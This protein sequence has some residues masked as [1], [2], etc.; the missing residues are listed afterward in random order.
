MSKGGH[1]TRNRSDIDGLVAKLERTL[2]HLD[3]NTLEYAWDLN[4]LGASN[5]IIPTNKCHI[6]LRSAMCMQRHTEATLMDLLQDLLSL[7]SFVQE[8]KSNFSLAP[9]LSR[10]II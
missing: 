10:A 9:C 6:L 4:T 8:S 1:A 5:P 3:L 2:T 7:H